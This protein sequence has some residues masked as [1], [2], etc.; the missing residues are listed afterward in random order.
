MLLFQRVH[1]FIK[2]AFVFA[3][4]EEKIAA[5]AASL[6]G[7]ICQFVEEILLFILLTMHDDSKKFLSP[8]LLVE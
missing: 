2:A 3:F 8:P 5:I 6:E 7:C 1:E 4:L